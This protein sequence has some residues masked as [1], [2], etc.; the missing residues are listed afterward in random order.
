MA[1]TGTRTSE[2]AIPAPAFVALRTALITHVGQDAAASALRMAGFAAGDAFYSILAESGEDELRR[3]SAERFW[4]RFATLFASRGWG[5]LGYSEAHPGVGS[6]AAADWAEGRNG[7]A[8]DRPSC[9]FTTGLLSSLLGRVAGAEVGVMEVE[10]RARGDARC[11]FLFGGTDAVY[12]VYE[13]LA[14]GAA[15]DAALQQIG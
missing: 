3:L 11:R 5:Q 14:G 7:E 9:H 4:K 13:R 15:A 10:C 6:L 1:S 2:L 12:A 8:A